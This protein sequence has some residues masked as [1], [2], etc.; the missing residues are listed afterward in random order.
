MTGAMVLGFD[1]AL[2][3]VL[4]LEGGKVD[5]PKD[6]GGR[7]NKGITQRVYDAWRKLRK[8][9]VRDVYLIAADEVRAIYKSQYW[10]VIRGDQL[11]EGLG[12]VVFDGAVNSGP[13][14]SVK[15][16]QRALGNLYTGTVDGVMGNLTLDAV[17]AVNDID[18]LIT[19]ILARRMEFL[20]ALKTWATFGRG[21]KRRVDHVRELGHAWATGS[22]GPVPQH[23]GGTEKAVIDDAKQ[24]PG[25]GIADAATGGGLSSGAA[26]TALQNLQDQLTPY[27]YAGGWISNLVVFLI[28]AGAVL[29]LG[30]LAY[31][32][33]ASKQTA[34][35]NDAL[36]PD[37]VR[38]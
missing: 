35:L 33:W 32:F 26:G 31:R 10:D 4:V 21:W 9:S 19:R 16:L 17:R 2:P 36:D 28:I 22:V 27:S 20:Q 6:P 15:W 3:P 25:K 18:A 24:A 34:K 8:L 11:P 37:P 7:T 12:F 38:V 14:Q 13:K 5:H 29:A 23:V 1:R 30:G